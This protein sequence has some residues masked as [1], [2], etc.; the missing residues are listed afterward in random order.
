MDIKT[1]KINENLAIQKLSVDIA[2]TNILG[3]E[4]FMHLIKNINIINDISVD[5]DRESEL[6]YLNK[7]IDSIISDKTKNYRS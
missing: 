4:K 6:K 2:L 3:E 7:H 5:E 1:D